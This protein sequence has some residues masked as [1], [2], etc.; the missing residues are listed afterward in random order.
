MSEVDISSDPRRSRNWPEVDHASVGFSAG[1]A[2]H[3]RPLMGLRHVTEL[4][5]PLLALDIDN[6]DRT[7][8]GV[9]ILDRGQLLIAQRCNNRP[10]SS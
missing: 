10:R 9:V 3:V 2:D 5:Q 8:D 4:A 6:L 7:G 1:T